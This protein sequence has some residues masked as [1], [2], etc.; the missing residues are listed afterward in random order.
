MVSEVAEGFGGFEGPGMRELCS[1]LGCL[2]R[3]FE[4]DDEEERS[5]ADVALEA[6]FRAV[7][8]VLTTLAVLLPA[9]KA[10]EP[11]VL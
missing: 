10:L 5:T 9:G 2:P 8:T 3:L 4:L 1:S 7:A 6:V 11:R